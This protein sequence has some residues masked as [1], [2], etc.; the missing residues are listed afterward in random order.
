MD[1][2]CAEDTSYELITQLSQINLTKQ[3]GDRSINNISLLDDSTR[4]LKGTNSEASARFYSQLLDVLK[5]R[6]RIPTQTVS[7][8][9]LDLLEFEDAT[10][11]QVKSGR[12]F[13]IGRTI[14]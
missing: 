6:Q 11:T 2:S 14:R 9:K 7:L 8:H 12:Y 10:T 13:F 5:R 1:K 3:Q 4:Q